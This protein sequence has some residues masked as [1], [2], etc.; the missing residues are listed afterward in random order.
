MWVK[1]S[2]TLANEQYY[3][4]LRVFD[5]TRVRAVIATN[6][7]GAPAPDGTTAGVGGG[8]LHRAALDVIVLLTEEKA[9]LGCNLDI[10]ACGGVEDGRT[11]QEFARCGVRAMQYWSVLVYRGPLAA[12]LI[13]YEARQENLL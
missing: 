11:Y 6:T 12:A 3:T 5:E 8:K 1:I 9:R 10:I 13:E 7:L 4:L 2:P